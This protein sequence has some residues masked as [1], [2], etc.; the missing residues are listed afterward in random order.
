MEW[1][2]EPEAS[3]VRSDECVVRAIFVFELE[4]RAWKKG[5]LAATAGGCGSA[6]LCFLEVGVGV[7]LWHAALRLATEGLPSE[8]SSV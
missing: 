8:M 2:A 7:A 6:M 4:E 3:L 5:G 1:E